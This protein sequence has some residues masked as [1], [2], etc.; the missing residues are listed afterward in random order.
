MDNVK[1]Q[2]ATYGGQIQDFLSGMKA[3]IEQYKFLVE[4]R[5]DGLAVDIEFKATI[6]TGA[7]EEEE[8]GEGEEEP[9]TTARTSATTSTMSNP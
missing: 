4:K 1:T 3:D 8:E 7:M 2:L 5:G 9:M 6:S